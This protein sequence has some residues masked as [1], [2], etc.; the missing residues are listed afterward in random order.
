MNNVLI[1]DQKNYKSK[2]Y[3]NYT[4]EENDLLV[5]NVKPRYYFVD[6]VFLILKN[7]IDSDIFKSNDTKWNNKNFLK[8]HL[9]KCVRRGKK[10]LAIKS[11]VELIKLDKN[12]FIRRLPIIMIEDSDIFSFFPTLIWFM[13]AISK[14]YNLTNRDVKYILGCVRAITKCKS[15]FEYSSLKEPTVFETNNNI[16]NNCILLR[17]NYG[18]M[19][20][21][22][23][24][25]KKSTG[26]INNYN[27]LK[28]KVK[29]I[30]INDTNLTLSD[31]LPM[32]MDFHVSSNILYKIQDFVKKNKNIYIDI[33][34]IK[35]WM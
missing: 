34:T 18:G 27:I 23:N 6:K 4:L 31:T 10:K 35:K 13:I 21:D 7:R 30:K 11:A 32:G 16:Y 12:D 9:Q 28:K 14:G 5:C 26:V 17:I 29:F 3:N 15:K 2:W 22:I 8:S 24:M 1:L 20:G 25:L 33:N 19:K